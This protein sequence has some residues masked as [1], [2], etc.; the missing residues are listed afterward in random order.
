MERIMDV[1]RVAFTA[2]GRLYPGFIDGDIAVP[3]SRIKEALI[4]VDRIRK[5]YNV[6]IATVGHAGDGNL[7]PNIGADPNNKDEWE[8]A[9]KAANEINLLAIEL[10]GT[11]SAEHGIGKLKE[12]VLLKQFEV[13]GQMPVYQLMKEIKRIFDPKNILNP[14][15]YALR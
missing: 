11:V 3:L 1:R 12:E 9:E 2:P 5:K 10:G 6:F 4:G 13:R 8:R 15:K 14:D 7:H